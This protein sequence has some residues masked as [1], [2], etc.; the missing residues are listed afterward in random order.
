[1]PAAVLTSST[2]ITFFCDSTLYESVIAKQA[3]FLNASSI[4]S[5]PSLFSPLKAKKMY[6]FFTFKE[7]LVRPWTNTSGS[8]ID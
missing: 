1:M 3:P 8:S 4:K 5:F 7:L 2:L 6:P